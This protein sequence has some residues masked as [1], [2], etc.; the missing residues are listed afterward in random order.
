[1]ERLS[2]P[3][4]TGLSERLSEILPNLHDLQLDKVLSGFSPV[5][6]DL[7]RLDITR[8]G[9]LLSMR[10]SAGFHTLAERAEEIVRNGTHD[11]TVPGNKLLANKELAGLLP[12][13]SADQ[14]STLISN[15]NKHSYLSGSTSAPTDLGI[16]PSRP[17][18]A[19]TTRK[20]PTCIEEV[21][22]LLPPEM[23]P[24]TRNAKRALISSG[25]SRPW[26]QNENYPWAGT[27]VDVDLSVPSEVHTRESVTAEAVRRRKTKSLDLHSAGELSTTRKGIDIGSIL[28]HS[29][30]GAITDEQCTGISHIHQRKQS[31]RSLIG[32][33]TK[34]IGLGGSN[35]NT[36]RTISSP[37][38][39]SASET[40]GSQPH[41]PGERY[42]TSSLTPPVAFNLDEVR[43]YFSDNSSEKERNPSL[44]KR[45][46]NFKPKGKSVRL[47]GNHHTHS[48]TPEQPRTQSAVDVNNTTSTLR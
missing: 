41:R 2:I 23:N 9:T 48:H 7:G 18:S 32:S 21:N 27:K 22:L 26:N 17:S 14:V 8:P 31:K 5:P 29:N 38:A 40:R 43:S 46:T 4:V 13:A 16:E 37:I 44:R 1:M 30:T 34:K 3:S 42:P 28:E 45:L 33:I 36:T 12:S 25:S 11:S 39:A 35:K 6:H 10:T 19:L 47:Q 15:D 20:S 24:I